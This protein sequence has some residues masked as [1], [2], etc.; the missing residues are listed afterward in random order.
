MVKKFKT[1]RSAYNEKQQPPNL[2]SLSMGPLSFNHFLF[3][4]FWRSQR[5]DLRQM[6]AA[7]GDQQEIPE[8]VEERRGWRRRVGQDVETVRTESE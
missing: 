3:L 5:M 2:F 4:V 7:E 8:I 1:L 6:K